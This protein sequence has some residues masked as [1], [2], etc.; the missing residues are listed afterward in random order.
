MN[1][2]FQHNN[3][4]PIKGIVHFRH[5]SI[6]V[7]R[8]FPWS[9]I[10]GKY[11]FM[12]TSP[13]IVNKIGKVFTY[14]PIIAHAFYYSQSIPWIIDISVKSGKEFGHTQGEIFKKNL[15]KKY[16]KNQEGMKLRKP[17][18]LMIPQFHPV[19]LFS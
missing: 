5:R 4:W 16:I 6:G 17:S 13:F 18:I 14:L 11:C 8:K 15:Q 2:H 7:K 3:R 12:E 19:F 1:I 9:T 10:G